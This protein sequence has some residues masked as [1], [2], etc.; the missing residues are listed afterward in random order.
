[1]TFRTLRSLSTESNLSLEDSFRNE[2]DSVS[3]IISDSYK[4][5][6]MH[7]FVCVHWL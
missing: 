1:M 6:P 7:V 2:K 3:E 5:L 4:E